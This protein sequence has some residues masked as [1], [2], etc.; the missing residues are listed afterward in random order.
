MPQNIYKLSS[1]TQPLY[2]LYVE[3]RNSISSIYLA[4]NNRVVYI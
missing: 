3:D 1:V 4:N 2:K